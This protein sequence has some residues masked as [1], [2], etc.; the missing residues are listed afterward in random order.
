MPLS[1]RIDAWYALLYG[2]RKWQALVCL[3]LGHRDPWALAHE[4]ICER[5]WDSAHLEAT[6]DVVHHYCKACD[7][8]YLGED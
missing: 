5:P 2:S 4:E 7:S 8:G 1:W 6:A 3:L